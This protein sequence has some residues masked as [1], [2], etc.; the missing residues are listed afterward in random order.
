MP[1][2]QPV[3]HDP[4]KA[5]PVD[6]DPFKL[7]PIDHDPFAQT[8][9]AQFRKSQ[10]MPPVTTPPE[11][12]P[13]NFMDFAAQ[14]AVRGAVDLATTPQ[15]AYQQGLPLDEEMQWS[16][17]MAGYAA[18]GGMPFAEEGSAGIFGG[19][20]SKT[21]D[22]GQLRF[23]EAMHE[24]GFDR[25]QIWDATG[26]FQGKDKKWRYEIPD[27]ELKLTKDHP[28]QTLRVSTGLSKDYLK[29]LELEKAYPRL[30]NLDSIIGT[31]S[32]REGTG[33]YHG[34]SIVA[35]GNEKALPETVLH[36]LQHAIQE[37]E[38]F[39]YGAHWEN[40]DIVSL[41]NE[42]AKKHNITDPGEIELLAYEAYR[43]HAGEVEAFNV[44]KRFKMTPA[45]R[46][47]KPP[48]ETEDRTTEQQILGEPPPNRYPIE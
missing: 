32:A 13:T 42:I 39:S 3:A 31:T 8:G 41:A 34:R 14:H 11:S 19:R 7:T 40:P 20:L 16:G 15:K 36:E 37:M 27:D 26:W 28:D 6:Y 47:A 33:T 5:V 46:K 18:G 29:H 44:E 30:Q 43:R 10:G 2:L 4:F 45:Q 25:R 23:A 9:M 21:A 1:D 38:Q 24:K 22:Q 48:W 12:K 17:R 35:S